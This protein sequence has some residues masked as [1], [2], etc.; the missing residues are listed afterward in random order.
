VSRLPE[1]YQKSEAPPQTETEVPINT[2]GVMEMMS[3]LNDQDSSLFEKSNTGPP[4][5]TDRGILD[6]PLYD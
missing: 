3:S 4:M 5:E 2:D 1:E 6:I